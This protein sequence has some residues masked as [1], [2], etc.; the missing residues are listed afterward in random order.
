MTTQTW[1][2]G[3]LLICTGLLLSCNEKID[4]ALPDEGGNTGLSCAPTDFAT[5]Q[6]VVLN[7]RCTA[8]HG[9]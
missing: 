2:K 4:K 1:I 9:A 8:C 5:I 6:R 3:L 7:T